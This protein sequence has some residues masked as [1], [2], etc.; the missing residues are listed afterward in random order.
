MRDIFSVGAGAA[1]TAGAALR[2]V[3][4]GNF[5]EDAAPDRR[6]DHLRDA[7]SVGDGIRFGGKID[8]R[9]LDFAAVIGVDDADA[10]LQS[11][12]VLDGET[13]V[14]YASRYIVQPL[15]SDIFLT[16]QFKEELIEAIEGSQM[17]FTFTDADGVTAE[18][19]ISKESTSAGWS[20]T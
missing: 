9:D 20:I 10:V 8:E 2:F 4:V 11:D 17:E 18:Y 16:R 1:E 15:M 13:E 7:F 19:V 6:E 12:A 14:A 5:R 3:K